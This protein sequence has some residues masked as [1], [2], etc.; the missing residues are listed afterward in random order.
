MHS[1]FINSKML[2]NLTEVTFV[3]D[4]NTL[5]LDTKSWTFAQ[6]LSMCQMVMLC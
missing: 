6:I 3:Y 4:P 5:N 1:G 2:T